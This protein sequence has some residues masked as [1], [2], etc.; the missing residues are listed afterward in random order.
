MKAVIVGAGLAGLAAGHRLRKA[1]WQVVLLEKSQSVGGRALSSRQNGYLLE[2]G[3]T[4][5][6]TGYGA[7]LALVDELGLRGEIHESSNVIG[8]LRDGKLHEIDGTRPVAAIFSGA[9]GWRAKLRMGLAILD[10]I[11]LRPP[12]DP[13][14]VSASHRLDVESAHGYCMRR[15]SR[16][17]HDVLVDPAVRC[18]VLNRADKVSALEWFSFLRNLAGQK[19]LAMRGG[20]SQLPHALAAA[21]EVRLDSTGTHVRSTRQ[22]VE[23]M[24]QDA[25]RHSQVLEGDACVIATPLPVAARIVPELQQALTPL[26]RS[27]A[28]NRARLVHLGFHNRPQSRAIGI[29]VGAA[30]HPQ[31]GLIWLE[32]NKLPAAAPPGHALITAYFD[33]S[34]LDSVQPDTDARLAEIALAFVTRLFPELTDSCDLRHVVRWELGIPNPS[35]GIYKMV[36]ELKARLDPDSR[37]QLAGDYFTC[38][39]QNSAIHWGNNAA[40][41][42]IHDGAQH[43]RQR[44]S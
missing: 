25:Q 31:I 15:L 7:Y 8:L 21:L 22:G 43:S 12:I 28:Y 27:L 13:L 35:P 9:L 29:L 6:S 19:M 24:Y 44:T 11:A 37:I 41:R 18:Y 36:N 16:E 30:A 17:I 42:L 39:G 4:Q 38:T 26:A 3:A 34:G 1:G 40:D 5:I 32:H 10:F 2:N 20:L 23:V 33:E 14:D